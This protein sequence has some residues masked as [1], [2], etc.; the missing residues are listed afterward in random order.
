MKKGVYMKNRELIGILAKFDIPRQ[1]IAEELDISYP[2]FKKKVENELFSQKEMKTIIR[3]L[4]KYDS[5]I[6]CSI[7]FID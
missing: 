3:Y 4:K 6:N 7:F 5:S 2:T 1:K